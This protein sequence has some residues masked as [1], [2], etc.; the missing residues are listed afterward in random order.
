LYRLQS[1][2]GYGVIN[3]KVTPKTG[4]VIGAVT[5]TDSDALLL[6]TSTNKIIRFGVR[7]INS[8]GRNTQG[9]R[10]VSI[11]EGGY[12]V[13]VYKVDESVDAGQQDE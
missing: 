11:D 9:V 6:L 7:D 8:I 4:V 10:L 13:S 12:V 2:G 3:F 1:R 5:V